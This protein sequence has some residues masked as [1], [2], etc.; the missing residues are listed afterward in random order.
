V[1]LY[2]R[3]GMLG[4]GG[5]W[6]AILNTKVSNAGFAGQDRGNELAALWKGFQAG[7]GTLSFAFSGSRERSRAV[8][9]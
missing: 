7:T 1:E 9:I 8:N 3:R 2:Q 6:P 4:V 5:K